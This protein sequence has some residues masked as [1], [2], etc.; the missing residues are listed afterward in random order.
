MRGDRSGTEGGRIRRAAGRKLLLVECN[1]SAA[2]V[3]FGAV[4]NVLAAIRSCLQGSD[5][6]G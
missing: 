1:I 6:R 4:C 3:F 2:G 5:C